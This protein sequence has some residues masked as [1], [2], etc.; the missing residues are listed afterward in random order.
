MI[1]N[2]VL[3]ALARVATGVGDGEAEGVG[4]V[5]HHL[6]QNGRLADSGGARHHNWLQWLHL[7]EVVSLHTQTLKNV[8]LAEIDISTIWWSTTTVPVSRS[9]TC[10]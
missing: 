4:E 1:V 7:S 8:T 2:S 5:G 6:F 9:Q 3:L 10:P